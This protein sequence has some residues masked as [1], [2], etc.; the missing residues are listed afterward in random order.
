MAILFVVAVSVVSWIGFR[1]G[2]SPNPMS[3]SFIIAI[4][5]VLTPIFG[6]LSLRMMRTPQVSSKPSIQ[7]E[8][9]KNRSNIDVKIEGSDSEFIVVK[10][11]N[12]EGDFSYSILEPESSDKIVEGGLDL[13]STK[14]GDGEKGVII[15]DKNASLTIEGLERGSRIQV[16]SKDE[17]GN[18]RL[19]SSTVVAGR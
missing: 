7:T 13:V 9:V 11:P 17:L 19:V 15:L 18:E 4:L 16:F 14:L 8:F 2:I 3:P 10:V 12:L 6:E 5:I 1:G